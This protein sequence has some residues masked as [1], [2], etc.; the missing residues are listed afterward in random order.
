MSEP[1]INGTV[2]VIKD[3]KWI[4]DQWD[5]N[6]AE[7]IHMYWGKTNLKGIYYIAGKG[8]K[9]PYQKKSPILHDVR[10]SAQSQDP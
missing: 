10:P 2:Y 9:T 4:V 3:N 1:T 5:M 8:V 6:F 7:A